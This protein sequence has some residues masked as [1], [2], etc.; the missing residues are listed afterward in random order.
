MRRP[1]RNAVAALALWLGV[2]GA[3]SPALAAARAV[4][5]ADAAKP[6]SATAAEVANWVLASGDNRGLPFVI[7]D[8]VV[9]EV[10]VFSADGQEQGATPALLG[11]ARGDDSAPHIGDREMSAIR[12][13]ERTTP[14][15]RFVAG[16]GAAKGQRKVL[17]VD[18]ATA[19]SMHPVVTANPKEHRLQRLR[20]PSP[21]DNRITFGCINVPAAFYDAVVRPTFAGTTGVVYIL[22]ETRPLDEVFPTFRAP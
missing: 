10:F 12:P 17:W 6:A 22:P 3:G 2:M 7:I 5:A 1:R 8:K 18:Y 14:A 21:R 13:G 16:F 11:L 4:D 15:G 20:S 19:I 9:A